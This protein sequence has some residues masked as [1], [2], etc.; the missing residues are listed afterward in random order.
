MKRRLLPLFIAATLC[1]TTSVTHAAEAAATHAEGG[2]MTHRMMMLVI[3]L[4]LLLF[5]A[6]LGNILFEK[7]KLPGVLGEL[8]SGIVVGPYLLGSLALPGFSQGLFPLYSASFPV[9][10]EL[11]GFCTVA[12][13]VLLFMVGLETDIKLFMRY[14][15]AGSLVGVGGVLGSFLVG[16][17]MGVWLLPTLMDAP[18]TMLSPACI[19]LGIMSTATSVGITARILSEKRSLESPEGVTILAGAV[20]DDVLGIVLLAVGLG[21]IAASGASSDGIAWGNIGMI[22]FKA[23]GIWLAAT[24]VGLLAA[25]WIS[26]MLK[27]FR[28]HTSIAIMALGLALILSGLFEEAKLAMIIGAYVMGLSLSRTDISHLIRENLHVVYALLV[29][30]FFAVMGML[31]NVQ[32]LTSSKVLIFGLIY[33][34]GAIIA[35]VVGCALPALCCGFNMRGA[36][37]IGFGML[38]RGEVAL[39]IAGIGLAAGLLTPEVFGVGVMMT[40]IT[41]LLAPPALV[42]MLKSPRTGLRRPGKQQE[43]SP[44][45]FTF[46]S[47][48]TAELLATKL[49]DAF[50]REGFFVHTLNHE[51]NIIQLRKDRMVIGFRRNRNTIIFECDDTERTFVNTAMLEVLAEFEQTISELRRPVDR[52]AIARS[53]QPHDEAETQKRPTM[54]AYLSNTLITAELQANSKAGVIAELIDMLSAQGL[55]K[56]SEEVQRAVMSREEIMSTGMQDG[57]AIPH[58]RT[59]ATDR[60]LCAVGIKAE[61]LDFASL[62]GEPSRIFVLTLSPKSSAAPHMQFMAT[63]SNCLDKYGREAMLLCRTPTE[64]KAVLSGDLGILRSGRT[65]PVPQL[66]PDGAALPSSHSHVSPFIKRAH[67]CANLQSDSKDGVID[68]LLNLLVASGALKDVQTARLAVFQREEQL[69]TGI[70]RGLAI[71]HARTDAVD[72]LIC[73]VGIHRDGVKFQADDHEPTQIVVLTITPLTAPAPHVQFMATICRFIDGGGRDRLLSAESDDDLWLALTTYDE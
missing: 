29:P 35:K 2:N 66:A 71:P 65:T 30:I 60:L 59:D 42:A 34:V 6:K 52:Q 17:L 54:K 72:E 14:S 12:S 63:V 62:D 10:P 46:P 37:R 24:I 31:V 47:V 50:R 19:F 3:Q 45:E 67:I 44:I 33:T 26:S 16:D 22:A 1:L 64:I 51:E 56:D 5:C 25:R 69:S 11:Y 68:E 28:D 27:G 41:T 61:G 32:L 13:I 73:A 4:G 8:A 23:I 38:P 53:I 36:M 39:I 48:D 15:V 21:V 57:I 40:L 9:S 70:Q 55:L 18:V 49:T 20:I 43:I 7:L 58:A